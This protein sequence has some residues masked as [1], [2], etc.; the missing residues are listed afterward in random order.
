MKRLLAA[1]ALIAAP[2]HARDA[3]PALW[4]VKDADTTIYL[5]GTV[6]VLP[7]GIDW[8]KADVKKAY[9]G[10]SE[11]VIE[12]IAPDAVT[13]Q[14]ATVSRAIEPAGAPDLS[15]KLAPDTR[16]KY[17]AAMKRYGLPEAAF[18]RFEPWFV[19][20]ALS[21]VPLKALGFDPES[22]VERT[23]TEA[24]ARDGKTL[25]ELET[26]DQQLG[27]FDG[28]PEPLQLNFLASTIDELGELKPQMN[29]M[30]D[31]W[32]AGNPD[33]LGK[34]LNESLTETPELGKIL[35]ADRNA[36]WAAWIKARLAKPGTVFVAV[37]AGHLAGPQSVQAK[38]KALG[39]DTARVK[40]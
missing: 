10:A 37:G 14:K 40:E 6:H 13:A 38:L 39:L 30:I 5:F 36:R 29:A 21:I 32:A 11:V 19:A 7:P 23:L 25:G 17:A 20:T 27:Y 16:A 24:A 1:L 3:D 9:D 26:F 28:L 33:A 2:V 8:F 31:A 12:M 15:D 22:G 18:E 35:L 34:L 4:V